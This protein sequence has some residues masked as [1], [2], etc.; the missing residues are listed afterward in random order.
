MNYS[1]IKEFLIEKKNNNEYFGELKSPYLEEEIVAFEKHFGEK[2][3][4]DFRNYLINVSKEVFFYEY[5]VIIDCFLP[6]SLIQ[7]R[8]CGNDFTQPCTFK[9]FTIPKNINSWSNYGLRGAYTKCP[10]CKNEYKY[11]CD[12][13]NISLKYGNII[14]GGGGC[15]YTHNLI[16]KGPH[17]GTVWDID[18]DGGNMIY[19]SFNEYIDDNME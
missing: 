12:T 19:D 17:K 2:L 15:H 5:L 3:P 8:L 4:E 14:V 6:K 11:S 9:P 7:C 13:C 18:Q 10:K 16:I 1:V